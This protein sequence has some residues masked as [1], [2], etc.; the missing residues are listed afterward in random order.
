[1]APMSENYYDYKFSAS[2]IDSANSVQLVFLTALE[3]QLQNWEQSGLNPQP[4]GH[5]ATV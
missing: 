5:K 2:S 1:M 4:L 3:S